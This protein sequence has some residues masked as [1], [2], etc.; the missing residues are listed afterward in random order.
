[1]HNLLQLF[2]SDSQL[3]ITNPLFFLYHSWI[4]YQLEVKIRMIRT[5]PVSKTEYDYTVAWMNT[6]LKPFS[7]L[8]QVSGPGQIKYGDYYIFEWANPLTRFYP[9]FKDP[10]KKEDYQA[11]F[12]SRNY[13]IN[14]DKKGLRRSD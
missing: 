5:S 11:A 1:M 4:D 8:D 10:L 9:Q 6:R 3:S 13:I 2:M 14:D 12:K 7:V